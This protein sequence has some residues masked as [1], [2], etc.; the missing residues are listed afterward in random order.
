MLNL[1][2]RDMSGN[3]DTIASVMLAC[4]IVSRYQIDKGIGRYSKFQYRFIEPS[5][6]NTV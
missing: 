5:L 3:R 4:D 2:V 6:V 1:T